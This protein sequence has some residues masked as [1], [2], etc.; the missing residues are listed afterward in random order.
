[1]TGRQLEDLLAIFPQVTLFT[2]VVAENGA[3]LYDPACREETI[4]ATPPPEEFYQALHARGVGSLS[5]GRVIVATEHPYEVAV[6]DTIQSLGLELQVIFNKGS[7]MI[8]PS[9][10]NKATGLTAALEEVGLSPHNVV[11]V[12]D[13][14][15]DHAFL[16]LCECAVAVANALPM[17]KEQADVVTQSDCGAGVGELI[18]QLV[19]TDLGSVE[20]RLTRH[21]ILLGSRVDGQEEFLSPYGVNLLLAGSSGGGKSTLA[22]GLLERLTERHYQYCVIDPEGDYETL[23]EAIALGNVQRAPT[24]EEVLQLLESAKNN[25]VINLVG[26]PLSERLHSSMPCS[27]DCKHCAPARADRTG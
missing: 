23:E 14:E 22:I 21:H 12:G 13:A 7:V 6:L 16:R 5:R 18:E 19:S 9:G 24:V 11:G 2:R 25:A 15:N 4:L 17:L 20:P 3:V 1:V 8:L 10:V 26:L 27:P